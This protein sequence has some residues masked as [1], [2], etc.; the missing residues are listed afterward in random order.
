MLVVGGD[1]ST[2]LQIGPQEWRRVIEKVKDNPHVM[3][4]PAR[5]SKTR[6]PERKLV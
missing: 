6:T 3:C 5:N 1:L 4:I 2:F